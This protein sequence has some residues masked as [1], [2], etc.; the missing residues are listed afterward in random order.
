VDLRK[1][2][3]IIWKEKRYGHPRARLEQGEG[4]SVSNHSAGGLTDADFALA[5]HVDASD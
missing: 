4:L 1:D 5:K 3:L 2:R